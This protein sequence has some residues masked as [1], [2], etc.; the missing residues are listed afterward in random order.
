M[1]K[2]GSTQKT[3]Y[4]FIL[5]Q[6]Y[7]GSTLLSF[8]LATQPGISTMGERRKFYNK[9]IKSNAFRSHRAKICSCNETFENC[10]YLNTLKDQVLSR[11]G[12]DKITS[13]TTEFDVSNNKFIKRI[14]IEINPFFLMKKVPLWMNPFSKKIKEL[15]EFNRI[16]VDEM[17]KLDQNTVFLD[18]SK[19]IKHV[20]YLSMIKEFD[21]HVV[22]LTRDPRAQVNSALKY[23]KSWDTTLAAKHW[24]A[25]MVEN[26][27]VLNRLN[28]KH[29][30]LAYED[31]CKSPKKEIS[32]ILDFAGVDTEEIDLGFRKKEQHIIGN[33]NM[34]LGKEDKIVER[35]EWEKE[36]TASQIEIIEKWTA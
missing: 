28:I 5:S 34:R 35:K 18:S 4:I 11:F 6:R 23:N 10:S 20:M 33:G 17:L 7:S 9:L 3:K 8:L 19:A 27:K 32:K 31:L 21:F 36:L 14:G 22:W 12:K 13:N 1:E 2:T 30:K 25:E 29:V 26:E 24:K 15:L 16:L